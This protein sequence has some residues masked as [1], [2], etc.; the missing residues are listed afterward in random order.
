MTIENG[1]PEPTPTPNAD[2][3]QKPKTAD[4][5]QSPHLDDSHQSEIDTY[6]EINSYEY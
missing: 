3:G 1:T 5:E 2:L 4:L 6:D